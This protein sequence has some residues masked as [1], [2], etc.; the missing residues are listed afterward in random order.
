MRENRKR[1]E[2]FDIPF[3]LRSNLTVKQHT[4]TLDTI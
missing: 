1:G 3:N 4:D 2:D